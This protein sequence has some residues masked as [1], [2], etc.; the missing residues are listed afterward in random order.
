MEP[1]PGALIADRYRVERKIASGGMGEVWIGQHP[2]GGRVALKVLLPDAAENHQVVTR[3]RREA[4]LLG[5]V[6]SDHVA[7]VIDFTS[8]PNFGF[9][10][11]MQFVEG[12]ALADVLKQRR[13]SIE[14]TLELGIDVARAIAD[15]HRANIV[16]R[17][18]KP[19]NII[20]QRLADRRRRAVIV[21]FGVSRLLS[22]EDERPQDEELTG[23]TRADMAVG[24]IVYMAPEQLLNSRDATH[25]ADIYALGA[26]L[27]RAAAGR[28][29]FGDVDD[30]TC[31]RQKLSSEAGPLELQRFDGAAK[32]LQRIVARALRRRPAERYESVEAM[33]DELTRARD[34]SRAAAF[35][36]E[37]PTQQASLSDLLGSMGNEPLDFAATMVAPR[38]SVSAIELDATMMAL[39]REIEASEDAPTVRPPAPSAAEIGPASVPSAALAAPPAMRPPPS[40]ATIPIPPG[41]HPVADPRARASSSPALSA[42]AAAPAPAWS[43]GGAAPARKDDSPPM[44]QGRS[45][46]LEATDMVSKRV[47]TIAVAAALCGG[48]VIGF[49]A[50]ALLF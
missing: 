3:F 29:V 34:A 6:Q 11:V 25:A 16:H 18:I 8:D 21:D 13:M 39:P 4:Y 9:V 22:G 36:V 47:A 35:A 19:E 24:T 48:L 44:T 45:M 49:A 23:I 43:N 2:Q 12:D 1:S 31:A 42:A 37:E 46:A 15:L 17:D 32:E 10:L 30:I 28:D 50:H 26:I 5:R 33:L 20:L 38:G 14:E 27:F 7:R 40:V 41:A